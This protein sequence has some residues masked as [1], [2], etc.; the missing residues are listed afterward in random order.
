[1]AACHIAASRNPARH[2]KTRSSK[3]RELQPQLHTTLQSANFQHQMQWSTSCRPQRESRLMRLR[4]SPRGA[5]EARSRPNIMRS[6]FYI[7]A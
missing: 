4:T 7:I 5:G 6:T 3:P 2:R 1:M